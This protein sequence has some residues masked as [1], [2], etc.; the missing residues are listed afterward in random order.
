ML[1]MAS[2]W[3]RWR[4]ARTLRRRAIPQP[5][6]QLTLAQFP[7]LARRSAADQTRLRELT[8]LF[9]ASKEFTGAKGLHVSDAM[10][11]AIAAQACLPIL[12]LG[13]PWYDRFVGI[14]VHDDAVVAQRET[15]DE[16]GVV[17]QYEE[18][19]SGEAMD[20]GPIML[21]WT[22]VSASG[23]SAEAGYNVVIHEFAH[24]LDL[25]DGAADG[26]PP[27]ADRAARERWR[28][29]MDTAYADFCA[30]VDADTQTFL[31]PYGAEGVDEFFAVASEAFFVAPIELRGEHP[32][33]YRLLGSFYLQDPA[34]EVETQK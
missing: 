33:L 11:V 30:E 28:Q 16:A 8:T 6:W 9:L 10:A 4:E 18:E 24:V 1:G 7:F 12:R 14:V 21:A 34:E 22:D 15:T 29:V 23:E 3:N 17:H 27:L 5:M 19:L 31:D 13:L 32:D 20:G 2:H 25:R 26:M